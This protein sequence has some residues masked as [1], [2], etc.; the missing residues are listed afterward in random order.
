VARE[1]PAVENEREGEGVLL[2][3]GLLAAS[4]FLIGKMRRRNRG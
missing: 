2:G 3:G 1:R 4:A